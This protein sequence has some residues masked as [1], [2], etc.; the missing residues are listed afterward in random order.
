MHKSWV[1][2][3]CNAVLPPPPPSFPARWGGGSVV[4]LALGPKSVQGLEVP[5][6]E[7]PAKWL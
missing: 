7:G 1:L 6:L 5:V 4:L 3:A 2:W